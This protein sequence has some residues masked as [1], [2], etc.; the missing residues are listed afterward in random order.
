MLANCAPSAGRQRNRRRGR[1][2]RAPAAR[3]PR[4]KLVRL[5]RRWPLGLYHRAG[6]RC[7]PIG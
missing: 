4:R 2:R 6:R 3:P 1:T 7:A 5:A